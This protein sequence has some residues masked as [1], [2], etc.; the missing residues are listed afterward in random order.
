[1]GSR[2]AVSFESLVGKDAGHTSENNS[3]RSRGAGT[4]EI[5]T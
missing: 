3:E 1:M 2:A 4:G 5:T